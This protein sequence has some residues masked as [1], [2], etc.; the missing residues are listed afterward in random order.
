MDDHLVAAPEDEYHGLEKACLGVEPQTQLALWP[1]AR[2]VKGFHPLR[3]VSRMDGIFA[4][5][6]RA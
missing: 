2:I 4:A 6:P 3:P 5:D 1:V